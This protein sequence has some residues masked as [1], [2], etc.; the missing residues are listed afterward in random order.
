M[1]P[2]VLTPKFYPSFIKLSFSFTGLSS[3]K[4]GSY[5]HHFDEQIERKCSYY[6]TLR[7]TVLVSFIYW[8]LFKNEEMKASSSSKNL[9]AYS[10]AVRKLWGTHSNALDKFM[11]NAPIDLSSSR[12]LFQYKTLAWNGSTWRL[13]PFWTGCSFSFSRDLKKI[14]EI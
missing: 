14:F 11:R 1:L 4:L 3:T 13:H 5:F 7:N 9:L 6:R 12:D 10:F 2:L 8:F